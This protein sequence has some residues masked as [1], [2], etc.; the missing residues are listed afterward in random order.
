MASSK[1]FMCGPEHSIAQPQNVLTLPHGSVVPSKQSLG[2]RWSWIRSAWGE[3]S[4]QT[5]ESPQMRKPVSLQSCQ[6]SSSGL[7]L[8]RSCF[9]QNV[10][11][12]WVCVPRHSPWED[13]VAFQRKSNCFPAWH[14]GW[15]SSMLTYVVR[16]I[17][18]LQGN[19]KV[20]RLLPQLCCGTWWDTPALWH[21]R[22]SA[23]GHLISAANFWWTS[24]GSVN[25]SVHMDTR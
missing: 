25:L 21:V 24:T 15:S 11:V 8:P 18:V 13:S 22:G 14:E 23:D 5:P 16:R 3:L 4:R 6:C 7:H 19:C 17:L 12:L 1:A 10:C 2:P 9:S 20:P